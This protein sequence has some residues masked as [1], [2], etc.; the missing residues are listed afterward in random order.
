VTAPGSPGTS[1]GPAIDAASGALDGLRVLVVG[2]GRSGLAAARALVARGA[3]VTVSA[4]EDPGVSAAAASAELEL[5]ALGARTAF[6]PGSPVVPPRGTQLVV[7]SPGVPPR[8]PLVIAAAAAGTPV[9]GEV[10]LAWRLRPD[11]ASGGGPAPWLGV[12][13]TNGKTTTTQ[14]LA[15]MLAAAGRRVVAAGNVGTPLV[16]VVTAPDAAALDV[17]AVELSSFQLHGT[18]TLALDAAVVLNLAADH[19]DWHGGPDAYAAAKARV[20]DRVRV[21][22]VHNAD[23]PATAALL[24]RAT[25]GRA[26][27]VV[28]TT[29]GVPAAGQLGLVDDLLVDRAFSHPHHGDVPGEGTVLASLADLAGL[30]GAADPA[31]LAG[32]ADPADPADPPGP[33]DTAGHPG[34]PPPHLVAD[35]LAA[36][37]LARSAGVPATAVAAGLR[38]SVLGP[39]RMATVAVHDGVRWVDDSKATNPHAAAASL[40]GSATVVWIAGGLAK[41]ASYEDLVRSVRGRLRGVVLLG[42]DRGLVADA[43]ARHAPWIPVRDTGAAETGAMMRVVAAAAELA[44][45]GDTVLLAPAAASHDQFSDYA[46]RGDAFAAEVRARV[47]RRG[48]ATTADA[49]AGSR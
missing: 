12:T 26:A 36:A 45:P 17:L 3:V 24:A 13:G 7:T 25:P 49:P 19:L 42:R 32:A 22:A 10:E 27:V 8:A 4:T 35:A 39:H 40:A 5:A 11:R 30:T 21:A 37:A 44:R 23:D 48:A 6:G 1:P 15:G 29:L 34:G 28:A 14:L 2:A 46:H 20:Y 16:E 33:A 47:G 9:W 18:T 38:G 31:G 41:G 43:L